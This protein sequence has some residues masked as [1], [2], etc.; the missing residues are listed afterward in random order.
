MA[1]LQLFRK[2]ELLMHQ[3]IL[4]YRV[5]KKVHQ[6]VSSNAETMEPGDTKPSNDI[7][8]VFENHDFD[9]NSTHGSNAADN[10]V[11]FTPSSGS[12]NVRLFNHIIT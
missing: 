12:N 1:E 10:T 5:S 9:S 2:T 4:G 6:D 3:N 7:Q 8:T 11:T